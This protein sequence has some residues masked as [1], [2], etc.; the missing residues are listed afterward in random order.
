MKTKINIWNVNNS[1]L[2]GIVECYCGSRYWDGVR[3]HSCGDPVTSELLNQ[4]D[5][6]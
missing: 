1:D 5:G 3:C 2:E 4:L 6:F